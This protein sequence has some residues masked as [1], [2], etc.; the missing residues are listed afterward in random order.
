MEKKKERKKKNSVARLA[1]HMT[2]T[3]G[4]AG[5]Q[6]AARW[7]AQRN[8]AKN[9]EMPCSETLLLVKPS[10]PKSPS[11]LRAANQQTGKSLYSKGSSGGSLGYLLPSSQAGQVQKHPAANCIFLSPIPS[12]LCHHY[13]PQAVTP[14]MPR[15]M[16]WTELMNTHLHKFPPPQME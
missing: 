2:G 6:S 10:S 8:L 9:K 13:P 12:C 11:S 15:M 7:A 5:K 16:T 4:V 1:K 3:A 14:G